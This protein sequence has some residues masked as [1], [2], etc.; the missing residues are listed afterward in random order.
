M[1][2]R[3]GDDKPSRP[4]SPLEAVERRITTRLRVETAE[5]NQLKGQVEEES[6]ITGDDPLT[7]W[8]RKIPGKVVSLEQIHDGLIATCEY[9]EAAIEGGLKM[10]SELHEVA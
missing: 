9:S 3:N 4:E 5:A 7:A 10:A 1:S 6:P 8:K 2:D